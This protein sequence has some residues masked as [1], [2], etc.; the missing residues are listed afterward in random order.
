M[1]QSNE[2][3]PDVKNQ[4]FFLNFLNMSLKNSLTFEKENFYL[5][6]SC[7]FE[8]LLKFLKAFLLKK[9]YTLTLCLKKQIVNF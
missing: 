7:H 8:M 5:L 3:L 6:N 9:M 1:L 4:N 2:H